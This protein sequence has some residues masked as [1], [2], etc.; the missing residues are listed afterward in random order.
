MGFVV[1]CPVS[2]TRFPHA[3]AEFAIHPGL[4]LGEPEGLT[5]YL[6]LSGAPGGFCNLGSG[7]REPLI[8]RMLSSPLAD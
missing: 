8:T 2:F 1:Q 6:G 4:R 3:P 5:G 7:S